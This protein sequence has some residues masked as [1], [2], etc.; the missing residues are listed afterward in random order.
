MAPDRIIC[1]RCG[2][3]LP[4]TLECCDACG[5]PLDPRDTVAS[6]AVAAS[7]PVR[8]GGRAPARSARPRAQGVPGV[9]WLF[10]VAGLAVGGMVGFAL[11]SAIGPR[12]EGG[13]AAGPADVPAGTPQGAP[14]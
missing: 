10:L 1:P 11:H 7:A 14:P 13:M 12:G 2:E 5:A 4:A 6:S 9:A 3:S 8:T